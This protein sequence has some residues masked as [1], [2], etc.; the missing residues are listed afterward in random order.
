MDD[1]DYGPAVDGERVDGDEQPV[2]PGPEAAGRDRETEGA[3]VTAPTTDGAPG[4]PAAGETTVDDPTAGETTAGETTAGEGAVAPGEPLDPLAKVTAE[5]D[6]Y[7]DALRRLQAEFD[8]YRKRVAKQ[9]AEEA[10]RRAARLVVELL[11]VLDALDLAASHLGEPPSDDGRALVASAAL[12]NDVLRKEGLE[13]IDPVGE[14]FD[15]TAH[16]AVGHLP[17]EEAEEPGADERGLAGPGSG[18]AAT[19]AGPDATDA[20]SDATGADA[21]S[22]VPSTV[23]AEVMRAG[24]RYRGTVVR[25]AMVLVRG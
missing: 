4:D 7:L 9:Q 25:P 10:D 24:Y 6:E 14:E 21:A 1:R 11:P 17:A 12:L 13:R 8:N 15:P 20:G 23:V 16:E 5:R 22:G 3:G 2:G 19:G 18:A